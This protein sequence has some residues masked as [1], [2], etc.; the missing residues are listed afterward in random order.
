M[1]SWLIRE[2]PEAGGDW[3]QEEK[4][5]TKD[6]MVG[7][8][9]RLDGYEFEQ[10]PRDNER[11]A[12]LMCFCSWGLKESDVTKRVSNTTTYHSNARTLSV[13][14]KETLY[15]LMCVCV[16]AW[17]HVLSHVRLFL[18]LWTIAHQAPLSMGFSREECWSVLVFPPQ[19]SNNSHSLYSSP[20]QS[21]I[22]FLFQWI[23]LFWIFLINGIIKHM[24]FCVHLELYFQSSCIYILVLHSF[25]EQIIF[26]PVTEY[27]SG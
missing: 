18:T 4:A 24:S 12:G 22:C 6:K 21:P 5:M 3:T 23:Y 13:P 20:W 19:L 16:C 27:W 1:K 25:Y 26:H 17:W 8:H 2:D 15:S 11:Q 7:W 9:H 10:G 14:P